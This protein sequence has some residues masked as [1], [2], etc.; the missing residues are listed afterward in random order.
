M[1]TL[2]ATIESAF[3]NRAEITH[4]TVT[5]RS[6]MQSIKPLLTLIQENFGSQQSK[7]TIGLLISG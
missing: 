7:E 4:K 5:A 2:Q 6:E 3:E 1:S